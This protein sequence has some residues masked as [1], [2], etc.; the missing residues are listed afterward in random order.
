MFE[1]AL[2]GVT[3][4]S[5]LY[6]LAAWGCAR[7]FF[8][9]GVRAGARE[10]PSVSVLKPA[11]G[12]DE[13]AYA[14]F[15]SFC[16]QDYP[17]YEVLFGVSDPNDPAV[18]VIRQLQRRFPERKIRLVVAGKHGTNPKSSILAELVARSRCPVLAISDSDIRVSPDYLDRVV[19]PLED[20]GIG[21][22]TCLYR[23]EPARGLTGQLA[24]LY[25]AASFFPSAILANRAFGIGFGLG[26]TIVL[27]R[28][29]LDRLGGYASFADHLADDY[30]I[31]ARVAASGR[32]VWLSE[33]VVTNVPGRPRFRDQWDREVRWARGLRA[34]RPGQ[35]LG[36]LLTHT[37]PLAAGVAVLSGFAPWGTAVLLGALA[38]RWLV[39]RDMAKWLS[40]RV[41]A[42]SFLCLPLRDAW[43]T[44]IWATGLFGRRI[45]W[46]GHVYSLQPG[47]RLLEARQWRHND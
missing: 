36:V 30:Q 33:H 45:V 15:A 5:I 41:S 46:R 25:L 34:D 6:W 2:T 42:S 9:R 18:P 32:R 44:A 20:P 14:N 7:R 10:R 11:K 3:L 4:A 28:G 1:I 43:S 12:V 24:A 8:R 22:V 35:Y 38:V 47:G 31:G 23:S 29:D 27:R 39:A 26:A 13:E 16:C 37:T 17:A 21:A 40:E 19:I